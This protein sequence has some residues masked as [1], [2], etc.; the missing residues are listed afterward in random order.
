MTGDFKS[1]NLDPTVNGLW[2]GVIVL[3]NAKISASNS[4]GDVSK[5]RLKAF[6]PLTPTVF[7]A[8]RMMQTIQVL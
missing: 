6:P 5:S 4:S 7:T 3:G 8:V 2:G 1:P